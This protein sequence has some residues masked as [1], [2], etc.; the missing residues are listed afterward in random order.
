MDFDLPFRQESLAQ[1][2]E[3]L[4]TKRTLFA[5]WSYLTKATFLRIQRLV[6]TVDIFLEMFLHLM[7]E[8]QFLLIKSKMSVRFFR[9]NL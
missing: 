7:V 2:R 9:K 1:I 3:Y 6:A 4:H 5:G 8:V